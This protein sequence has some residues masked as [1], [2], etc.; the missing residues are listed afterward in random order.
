MYDVAR[1]CRAELHF[2]TNARARLQHSHA[3]EIRQEVLGRP[4]EGA[5]QSLHPARPDVLLVLRRLH[6]DVEPSHKLFI[7]VSCAASVIRE[8]AGGGH[9]A[10]DEPLAAHTVMVQVDCYRCAEVGRAPH[11]A[12]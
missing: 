4:G 7:P 2:L 6:V 12:L 3:V 11:M 9:R 5:E 10:V 8:Y 1:R